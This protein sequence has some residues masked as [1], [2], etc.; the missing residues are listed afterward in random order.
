M[1]RIFSLLILSAVLAFPA[2]G[3]ST[4]SSL[5][6]HIKTIFVPPF[7]NKIDFKAG[8]PSDYV[9]LLEVKAH[10]ALINQFLFDGNLRIVDQKNADL[11]LKGEL[12][13]Y[14][15]SAM[16]YTDN[17]D[18]QEYRVA[19]TVRLTMSDHL[20][21]VL[22]EEP[23]FS[24]EGSYFLTGPKVTSESDALDHAVADLA[25]RIVERTVE[26]W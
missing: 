19:V 16:R 13:S 10:D 22:W 7:P 25:K 15:R 9:P 14:D 11:V 5:A 6:A 26:D 2:C 20:G 24:G 12:I 23:S 3:Y 8:K 21:Q 18:V 17:D 4:R 1:K